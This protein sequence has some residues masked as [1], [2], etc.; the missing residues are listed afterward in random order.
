MEHQLGFFE[1]NDVFYF[2]K[3]QD[4]NVEYDRDTFW[5]EFTGQK[6]VSYE[7]RSAKE[8]RIRLPSLKYL[9]RLYVSFIVFKEGRGCHSNYQ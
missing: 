3:N 9:H 1:L 2:F 6:R 4:A 8:S 7:A 5:R